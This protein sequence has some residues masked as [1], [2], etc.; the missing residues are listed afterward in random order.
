MS[1]WDKYK[2]DVP[3]GKSGVWEVKRIEVTEADANFARILAC[4]PSAM[5][6]GATI[7]P[8]IFTGLYRGSTL[9]MSD[10]PD[11]VRDLSYVIHKAQGRMLVN[12]LGLGVVV[13]ACLSKESEIREVEHLTVIEKSE[14]VL[15]L[16]GPHYQNKFGDRLELI[17][18]D[19]LTW[20]PPKNAHYDG[21]WH[22]IWDDICADNLPEM[23]TLHRRYGRR[24][25]WQG[26]WARN[27]CERLR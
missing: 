19:A 5:G 22:D 15:A 2:V 26:S 16:V 14:D 12:G 4:N 10:T 27:L 7:S 25:G 20:K 21:V 18:S 23:R 1:C 3:L 8:G 11:E 13:N 17:H 24:C 9:V 6:R